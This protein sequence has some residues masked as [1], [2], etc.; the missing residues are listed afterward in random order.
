METWIIIMTWAWGMITINSS[1]NGGIL[2]VK[3]KDFP[4]KNTIATEFYVAFQA[5]T[6]QK[7]YSSLCGNIYR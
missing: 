3:Q 2:N 4:S 1:C 6:R 7:V 5:T